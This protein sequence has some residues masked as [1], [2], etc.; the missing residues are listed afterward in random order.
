MHKQSGSDH[1]YGYSRYF[2]LI[3]RRF[4]T[5][6]LFIL[7]I[8]CISEHFSCTFKLELRNFH[9][10]HNS[11]NFRYTI[12]FNERLNVCICLSVRNGFA[13]IKMNIALGCNLCK[14][15]DAD[16]LSAF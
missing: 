8:A 5:N 14:V 7:Y 3:L 9:T 1:I 13:D 10:T 11:C 4:K 16:D 12:L 15:S 6:R 2:C